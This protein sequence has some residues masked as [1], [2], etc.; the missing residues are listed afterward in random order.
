MRNLPFYCVLLFSSSYG[1]TDVEA[2]IDHFKSSEGLGLKYLPF[3]GIKWRQ[4][5]IAIVPLNKKPSAPIHRPLFDMR[6]A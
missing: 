2:L 1:K 4:V 3:H 6:Y 5:S